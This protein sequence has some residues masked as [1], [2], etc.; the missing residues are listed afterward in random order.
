[1]AADP[2]PYVADEAITAHVGSGAADRGKRYARA[3]AVHGLT[4][5]TEGGSRRSGSL[6]G[7]VDGSAASPYRTLVTLR[8]GRTLGTGVTAWTPIH[9]R[10]SCPVGGECKHVAAVLHEST[11]SAMRDHLARARPRAA[12]AAPEPTWRELLGALAPAGAPEAPELALGVELLTGFG[13]FRFSRFGSR[14]ATARDVAAGAE[15][16][17]ALRPLQRGRSGSWIKGGLSWRSFRSPHL[18]DLPRA[19][20]DVLARIV[21]LSLAERSF[22]YEVGDVLRL[23]E[24]RGPEVWPLLAR[25]REVGVVLTGTGAV[26]EV[27]WSPEGRA[28]LDVRRDG[29]D[30][31][32]APVVE[33]A[34]A[35]LERPLRA[36]P[37]GVALARTTGATGVRVTLV[38]VAPA[39]PEALLSL[40]E[41]AEPVRVPAADADEFLADVSPQLR[42]HVPVSSRDPSLEIP[43]AVPPRLRL[44]VAH[45]EQDSAD[46]TWSWTYRAPRRTLD[47]TRPRGATDRDAAHEDAVLEAV[48]RLWPDAARAGREHL[49]GVDLAHFVEHLLPALASL[50]DVDVHETGVRADYTELDGTP[51]LRITQVEPPHGQAHDWFDLGFEITLGDVLV[52]F[53]AIFAALSGGKKAVLMPDKTYFRLDHPTFDRL[54]ELLAEAEQLDEW[55]PESPRLGRYQVQLWEDFED[56]A[57]E[58]VEALAW[59]RS[60]GALRDLASIPVPEPPPGLAAAL[61]PYQREGY[62]WLAF[63]AEHGLGGILADDMGLGKT[64]QTLALVAR[65]RSRAPDAPPFLV[66]APSSV[67]AVWRSEAERFTPGLDV[68]VL[69][70]TTRK[71]GTSVAAATAGTDLVVTSYAILRLDD[72]QLTAAD[73]SG[74]VLDEAQF[75]KNR[76]SRAHQV[77]RSVRAP[78]RLAITGTPLE[79]SLTDLWAL[80]SLTAPGLFASPRAFREEYV[81]PI[82]SPDP[83]E[84]GAARAAQRMSRLRRRI[85]PFVLRRTKDVVA[86]ELP[87]KQEQVL[88]VPLAGPHRRLYDRVLQRERQKLLG[89]AG[90]IDRHRFIVFRSLT[91][92]RMLALDPAIV[93][94]EHAGVASSKLEALLENLDEVIAEHHRVLVFSQFTSHLARVAERL[95]ERGIAHAYLDGSTA[96]RARVVESFRTGDA[97]VFLISLKAGGFGLT[98]T[99]ADYVFL[100]DPWW[101]PAAEAQAVDRAHRLG[102]DRSVMVYRMVAEDT[103]EEKVLALQERKRTLFTSLTDDDRAFAAALTADDLRDLLDA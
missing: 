18:L 74:L 2:L 70:E 25:A 90:D 12:P 62:A 64:L 103:I 88:R 28:R 87:E 71:R 55:E 65:E 13:G 42:R 93:D 15:L 7:T 95:D 3:H 35:P 101:N 50:P 98:L 76:A 22:G 16:A 85:R 52:P 61:R 57:D 73:W 36:G 30:L 49:E 31:V 69:G 39:M 60:V 24:F 17:V 29:G 20:A 102:Q 41:R 91:L 77:A 94:A 32:V 19:Q 5:E 48:R 72:A 99:E 27:L 45:G 40:L 23:D 4:W 78:F 1:M 38:P 37:G 100:L 34:G 58:S 56:L 86:P 10:C 80:L 9:S 46:L 82:E 21:R 63:L 8:E 14:A 6:S 54:R 51:H 92:L 68:R 96:D 26:S 44:D 66:I 43:D 79:N 89:L 81:K 11:S 83:S 97:P 59:R 47:L 33:V 84:S 67:L 53:T 75:V